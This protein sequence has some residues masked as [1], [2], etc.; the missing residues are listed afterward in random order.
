MRL[1][2]VGHGRMGRLVAEHAPAYGC[3]GAGVPDR[4]ANEAGAGATA[5]RCRGVD[6]AVDFSTPEAT[7]AT[8]PRLAAP[9]VSLVVGTTGWQARGGAPRAGGARACGGA[10]HG[11]WTCR[12][13]GPGPFRGRTRSGSTERRRRSSS[14]TRCGTAPP[15][16]TGRSRQR[17]GSG[18]R[19]AGSG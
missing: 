17:G 2:V 5:D 15:S 1:L 10:T 7:L 19:R 11:R 16:R 3:E 18:G 12:P 13:R 8:V 6:V 14:S 9:G 4:A